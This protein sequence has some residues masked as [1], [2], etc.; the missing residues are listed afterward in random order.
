MRKIRFNTLTIQN[1]LSVGNDTITIEFQN[2]LNLITGKNND[3]PERKNGVGK[4]VLI[5]AYYYALFGKTIRE[6]KKEFIVNNVTKGKGAVS[7]QFD[8]ETDDGTSSYTV[9]RQVKPSKVELKQGDTDITKDSI[10]NTNKFICELIGSNPVISKSCDI[11]SLSDNTPFMAKNAAEKRKFIED[12]F[13]LEVY[14]KM[15][16]DLKELIKDN[17]AEISISSTRIEEMTN[18]LNNLVAQKIEFEKRISEREELLA[19]R[20]ALLETKIA[21]VEESLSE[22]V[23]IDTTLIDSNIEKITKAQDQ[24]DAV[25]YQLRLDI[26]VLKNDM[27]RYSKELKSLDIGNDI[28]CD[29]CHQDIPHSHKFIL[30]EIQTQLGIDILAISDDIDLKNAEL[31]KGITKNGKILAL[32]ADTVDKKSAAKKSVDKRDADLKLKAELEDQLKNVDDDEKDT[33]DSLQSF[34]D[35]ILLNKKRKDSE[36]ES[37]LQLKQDAEDLET[38]KFILGEEGVK[39][40]VVKKLLGMLNTSIQTY[41]TELGMTMRCKFDEYFDEQITNEKGKEIS[42][43]N[44]SGGERRTVDLACAWAFKDI[45]RKI[46]GISSNVEFCDEIFDS[47][48]DERGLD[49]LIEVLKS[50][51]DKYGMSIYAISHRKETMKHIDGEIVMLEKENGV[52]I[53]TED[54]S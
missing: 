30:K 21:T 7:L 52:T 5:D 53:R 34:L 38:C 16:K 48:F 35:N 54:D 18:A 6:I 2:G 1:F 4:S 10:D 8:V 12:I 36:S 51:I 47:A 29:K 3:N 43:W 49:L 28:K 50:R 9:T 33:S 31:E 23:E 19:Q 13:A 44:F 46:S 32:L 11:L 25:C 22:Y 15:A 37:L 24:N 17:K 20:R 27:S 39:S 42:Y 26:Q 41:I 45:K 40:F 14:G